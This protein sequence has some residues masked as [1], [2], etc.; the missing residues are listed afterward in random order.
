MF[1]KLNGQ[2]LLKISYWSWEVGPLLHKKDKKREGGDQTLTPPSLPPLRS[3]RS[4]RCTSSVASIS[5]RPRASSRLTKEQSSTCSRPTA[6]VCHRAPA[7]DSAGSSPRQQSRV[8]RSHVALS[9]AQPR[10]RPSKRAKPSRARASAIRV[11]H[12]S[13]TR[14]AAP[15]P[16]TRN[17]THVSA[18][19]SE[20]HPS[21]SRAARQHEPACPY[22]AAPPTASHATFHLSRCML[23][24]YY[25]RTHMDVLQDHHYYDTDMMERPDEPERLRY[26]LGNYQRPACSY[27]GTDCTCSGTCQFR[28]RGRGKNKSKMASD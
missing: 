13:P 27:G 17:S 7:A 12:V 25:S 3:C 2:P 8:K 6:V 14:I 5:S 24:S 16:P 20:P 26:S 28:G 1:I 9:L 10:R 11:A 19:R 21:A 15:S 18:L 23:A 22:R 4:R